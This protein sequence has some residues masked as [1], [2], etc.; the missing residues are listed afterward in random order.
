MVANYSHPLVVV[1]MAVR[2]NKEFLLQMS[3]CLVFKLRTSLLF[4]IVFVFCR[5]PFTSALLFS[6]DFWYRYPSDDK[7]HYF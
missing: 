6:F 5:L 1:T 4:I 3:V 2:W 7:V